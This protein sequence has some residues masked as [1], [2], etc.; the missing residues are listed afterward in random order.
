MIH[1]GTKLSYCVAD[2][3][4]SSEIEEIENKL[5]AKEW[6]TEYERTAMLSERQALEIE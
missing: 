3:T 5:K 4:F 6:T 2:Q 1:A